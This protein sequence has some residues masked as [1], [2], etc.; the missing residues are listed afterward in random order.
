MGNRGRLV[1]GL[2]ALLPL[3]VFAGF[4]TLATLDAYRAADETRLRS[5]ASAL[6]TAVD[7]ELGRYI[8]ALEV[9]SLSP[10][11]DD[12]MD[13]D[14]VEARFRVLADAWGGWIVLIDHPPTYQTLANTR[15]V[16]GAP[17]PPAM[18]PGSGPELAGSIA[19]LF[20]DGRP[21]VSDLF[22]RQVVGEPVY[23]AMVAVDRPGR[24]R[25]A[26]ALALRPDSLRE[27]LARQA[28][29]FGTFGAIAD[30]QFRVLG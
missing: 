2:G 24:P 14:A 26:L 16:A 8:A 27:L 12:P 1:S 25:R 22:T 19:S 7:A 11:L 17:L 9:L 20:R 15:R 4:A 10:L 6:A 23:A 29:P 13:V 18:P 5:T 30:R 3:V 21:A 28:L